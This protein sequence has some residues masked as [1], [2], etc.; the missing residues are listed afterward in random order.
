MEIKGMLDFWVARRYRLIGI[1][2]YESELV[3]VFDT[4]DEVDLFEFNVYWP[5][6]MLLDVK[7]VKHITIDIAETFNEV[8]ELVGVPN[9]DIGKMIRFHMIRKFVADFIGEPVYVKVKMTECL[10]E[11]TNGRDS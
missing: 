11:L 2:D 4:L 7:E 9:E 1:K 10:K 8:R 5:S 6:Y 3:L